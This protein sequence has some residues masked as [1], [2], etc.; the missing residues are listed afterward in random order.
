MSGVD[1]ELIFFIALM[2]VLATV[3]VLSILG[4]AMGW[5]D[6]SMPVDQ[7]PAKGTWFKMWQA[8]IYGD[9]VAQAARAERMAHQQSFNDLKPAEARR[10]GGSRPRAGSLAAPPRSA[11]PPADL[12]EVANVE[13]VEEPSGERFVSPSPPLSTLPEPEPAAPEP[14]SPPALRLEDSS[15]EKR[16]RGRRGAAPPL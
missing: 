9:P 11:P 3:F 14:L 2:I 1:G 15:S 16:L 13:E 8:L 6:P 5:S 12:P 4:W 10:G 7:N